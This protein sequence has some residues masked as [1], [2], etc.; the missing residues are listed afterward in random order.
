MRVNATDSKGR[1]TTYKKSFKRCK[2][3]K[4]SKKKR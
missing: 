2:A 3:K 4:R 1:A